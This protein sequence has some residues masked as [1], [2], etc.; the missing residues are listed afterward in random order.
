MIL[1][2]VLLFLCLFAAW[3]AF[4]L[5]PRKATPAPIT[6]REAALAAE[7]RTWLVAVHDTLDAGYRNKKSSRHLR[8]AVREVLDSIDDALR[9]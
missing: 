8:R 5:R 3:L 4:R 7:F 6:D 2:I 9:A 1:L